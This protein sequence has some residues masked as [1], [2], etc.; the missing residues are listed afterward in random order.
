MPCSMNLGPKPRRVGSAT[1]GPSRWT[2]RSRTSFLSTDD[3]FH[4]SSTTPWGIE[5]VAYLAAFVPNSWTTIPIP[6]EL[7][8]VELGPPADV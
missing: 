7:G 6:T 8:R 4:L 2:H 5:R 3:R 1:S